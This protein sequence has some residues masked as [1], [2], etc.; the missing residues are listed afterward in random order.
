MSVA[1][2][3]GGPIGAH[4]TRAAAAGEARA[5]ALALLVALV[6]PGQQLQEVGLEAEGADSVRALL[7][8]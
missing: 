1:S 7:H 3:L 4:G 5:G 8:R 2:D 6:L